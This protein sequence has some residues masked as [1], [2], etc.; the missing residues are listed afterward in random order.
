MLADAQTSG[1]LLLATDDP[2]ALV[3]ALGAA[4]V[5]TAAAIG[6]IAEGPAGSITIAGRLAHD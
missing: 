5:G 4:G 2:A 6:S 3:E 1:G